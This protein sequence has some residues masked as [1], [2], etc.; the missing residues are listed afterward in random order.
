M[1]ACHGGI[2]A[3]KDGVEL[4]AFRGETEAFYVLDADL[5]RSGLGFQNLHNLCDEGRER[6]GAGI[7]GAVH[8]VGSHVGRDQLKNLGGG[9]AQ[10][11]RA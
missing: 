8:Q 1:I 3:F 9:G 5:R 4:A 7:G 10:L 2:Q 11:P 6:H